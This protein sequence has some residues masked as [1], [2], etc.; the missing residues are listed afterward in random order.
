MYICSCLKFGRTASSTASRSFLLFSNSVTRHGNIF[1]RLIVQNV[2]GL[3]MLPKK[4][5]PDQATKWLNAP[6]GFSCSLVN[7]LIT[8]C[9]D[10]LFLT[11]PALE[12]AGAAHLGSVG[13]QGSGKVFPGW[14]DL[15]Q[16]WYQVSTCSRSVWKQL[17]YFLLIVMEGTL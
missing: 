17:L 15:R 10:R 9:K 12:N 5:L 13:R 4:L 11:S 16:A 2:V 3:V 6:W 1:V 8:C 7:V 14:A